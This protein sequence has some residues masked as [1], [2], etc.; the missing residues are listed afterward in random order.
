VRAFRSATDWDLDRGFNYGGD[1][2]RY[3][4]VVI[5]PDLLL[6]HGTPFSSYVRY[7][8]MAEVGRHWGVNL[9]DLLGYGQSAMRDGQDISLGVQNKV[10]AAFLT[11]LGLERP[12]MVAHDNGGATSLRAHLIN[13][14]EFERI[15]LID[16][17][18]IRPWRSPSV[19][20]V[21]RNEA[22]FQGIPPI[23]TRPLWRVIW[24]VQ[25]HAT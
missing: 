12:V 3:R 6:I 21:R 11:H 9:F 13:A 15:L 18:A 2:V 10:L 24:G 4:V 17:V 5:G 16:P 23:P 1:A 19:K 25:S 20:H 14:C 7:Q 8:I 22:T